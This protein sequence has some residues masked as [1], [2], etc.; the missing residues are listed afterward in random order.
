MCNRDRERTVVGR[1][2]ARAGPFARAALP[3]GVGGGGAAAAAGATATPTAAVRGGSQRSVAAI[4]PEPGAACAD[5]LMVPDTPLGAGSDDDR[6]RRS[7]AAIRPEPGAACADHLM[8][9]DTPMGAGGDAD[10]PPRA[11]EYDDD[12]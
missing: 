4:R 1:W 9:P 6:P 3:D 2:A 8:V 5:H 10:G 11:I 12:E 7:V